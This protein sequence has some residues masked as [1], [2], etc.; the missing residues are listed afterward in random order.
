MR[1]NIRRHTARARGLVLAAAFASCALAHDLPVTADA[2]ISSSSPYDNFGGGGNLL[3]GNGWRS[4]TQFSL[5]TLPSGVSPAS[6][7]KA[8]LYLWAN[9]VKTPGAITVRFAAKP[10]SEA[11]VTRATEPLP[12]TITATGTV[13]QASQFV[14]VDVTAAVQQFLTIP[15][16]NYGLYIFGDEAGSPGAVATFDSK[17]STATSH[18]PRIE[19]ILAG[20]VGP[21]GPAGSA[22][23]AG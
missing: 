8:T 9:T 20:P 3:V 7:T 13:V 12:G 15:A 18:L 23:P 11:A 2:T 10:W 16:G 22:G 6:V 1:T 21:P 5:A 4:L 19:V 14:L 17:E